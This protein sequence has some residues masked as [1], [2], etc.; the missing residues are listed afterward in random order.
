MARHPLFAA[1]YDRLFE[2]PE[3]AGLREMRGEFL[4]A[5][6]GRTL[7]LGAGTGLDLP[8]YGSGVTELVPTSEVITGASLGSTPESETSPSRGSFTW[9]CPLA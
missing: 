6:A 8:H 3:K 7:E 4:A 5:A 2:A 1:L 9:S